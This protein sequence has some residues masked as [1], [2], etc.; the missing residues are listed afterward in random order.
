MQGWSILAVLSPESSS[1]V[2]KLNNKTLSLT[3]HFSKVSQVYKV[4]NKTLSL[5]L[6][7]SKIPALVRILQRTRTNRIIKKNQLII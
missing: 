5:T 2:Y 4:T 6:H 7:F 3:L 1:Q